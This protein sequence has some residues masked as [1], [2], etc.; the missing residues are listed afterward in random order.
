MKTAANGVELTRAELETVIRVMYQDSQ[1]PAN[2]PNRTWGDEQDNVLR[3]LQKAQEQLNCGK[4]PKEK[5][6][7]LDGKELKLAEKM[8]DSLMAMTNKL[9]DLTADT[10][11]A[12][13]LQKQ[14]EELGKQFTK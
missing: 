9:V 3:N 2:V 14:V 10:G 8:F 5:H 1:T 4:A 12:A 6:S 11:K 7:F 13:D